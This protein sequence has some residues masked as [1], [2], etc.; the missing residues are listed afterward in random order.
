M[1]TAGKSGF[2][3]ERFRK[4]VAHFRN[5]NANERDNAFHLAIAELGK[6]S[7][8][9]FR[10]MPDVVAELIGGAGSK[11]TD[12]LRRELERQLAQSQ[13]EAASSRAE[14][15]ENIAEAARRK[16]E[17]AQQQEIIDRLLKRITELEAGA[18]RKPPVRE[19]EPEPPPAPPPPSS[20]PPW[21]EDIQ[22]EPEPVGETGEGEPAWIEIP[23]WKAVFW[24]A[25]VLCAGTYAVL[26]AMVEHPLTGDDWGRLFY[27]WWSWLFIPAGLIVVGRGL[28]KLAG[29]TE[30]AVIINHFPRLC[31]GIRAWLASPRAMASAVLWM[32]VGLYLFSLVWSIKTGQDWVQP[33]QLIGC[34][35][36]AAVYI[37]PSILDTW[38]EKGWRGIAFYGSLFVLWFSFLEV[39]AFN[40]PPWGFAKPH[41]P[42]LVR[43]WGLVVAGLLL[44][45]VIPSDW[46]ENWLLDD[47]RRLKWLS[48]AAL[49]LLAIAAWAVYIDYRNDSSAP[50]SVV[51]PSP[52]TPPA[53]H[54]KPKQPARVSPEASQ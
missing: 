27:Y 52:A 49:L 15:N 11:E 43:P 1:A 34:W 42:T 26:A 41:F 17:A 16:A 8:D 48:G 21:Y 14:A 3:A 19:Q 28:Y 53:S 54:A 23:T 37:G 10:E 2:N 51:P 7:A 39:A 46:L 32:V 20:P 44:V 38:K 50:Q 31:L 47:D 6:A 29:F 40:M 35:T 45:F 9:V 12:E 5:S 4:L 36:A 25:L 33:W 24:I 22:P 13:A 30:D 18:T